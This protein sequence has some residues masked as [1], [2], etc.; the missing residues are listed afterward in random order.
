MFCPSLRMVQ[1]TTTVSPYTHSSSSTHQ[2]QVGAKH[3]LVNTYNYHKTLVLLVKGNCC[4]S[5]VA[6]IHSNR[7]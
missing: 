5:N 2:E 3:F 6:I 1:A 4:A 7:W